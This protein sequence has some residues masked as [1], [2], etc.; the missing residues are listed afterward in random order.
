MPSFNDLDLTESRIQEGGPVLKAGCYLVETRNPEYK[1]AGTGGNNWLAQVVFEDT[2]GRGQITERF[3]LYHSS[4]EAQRIGREQFKTMLTH[5]GHPNP[6]K[7]H[8]AEGGIASVGGLRL[9]IIVKAAGTYEKNGQTLTSYE[10]SRYLPADN[11]LPTGPYESAPQ[12]NQRS[13]LQQSSQRPLDDEIP[14]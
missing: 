6:D 7:P 12:G 10:I 8:T 1:K 3:N 9:K 5:G 11:P 14:F 4:A 2:E 13:G